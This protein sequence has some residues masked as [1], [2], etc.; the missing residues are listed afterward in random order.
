MFHSLFE[1][2]GPQH[3][4]PGDSPFEIMVGAVLTQNTAWA[5]GEKAI[6]RLKTADM[7]EPRAIVDHAPEELAELIRSSGYFNLKARR[8]QSYCRFF[9]EA[10]GLEALAALPTKRL[11]ERLLAVHGVGPETAD[12]MLLY[13]FERPVFVVDAYTRR[14]GERLGI[15][16]GGAGYEEIR[17][18]FEGALGADV[19]ILNE[20][21]ALI[22]HHAKY[23][24]RKRPLCGECCLANDCPGKYPEQ[25]RPD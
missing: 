9:L 5:N 23:V 18:L 10:G 1:T 17:T 7:L 11:R 16:T 25:C 2:Y 14:I 4:W 22:V 3:W 12:D 8:L 15:L 24:C 13:A 21:H 6:D 19:R 20:L